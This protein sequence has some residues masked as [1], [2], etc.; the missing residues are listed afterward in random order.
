MLILFY[1]NYT[2]KQKEVGMKTNTL[3]KRWSFIEHLLVFDVECI[4]T[5]VDI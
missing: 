5:G 2:W 3:L 1:R 4:T